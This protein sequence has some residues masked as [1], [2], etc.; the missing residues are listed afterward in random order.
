MFRLQ[1][2]IIGLGVWVIGTLG[3]ISPAAWANP[4]GGTGINPSLS[5]A[6]TTNPEELQNQ[7]NSI[8]QLRD[9]SP[10]NWSYEALRNLVENYGCIQGYPDRTYR[11]DRALTRN[12]FAAGLSAC[13]QQLERRLLEAR[14]LLP[15]TNN[16]VRPLSSTPGDSLNNVFQRAFFNSTGT[17]FDSTSI[18]GQAN[19]IFGWR[20]FPGSFFDNQIT[21]DAQVIGTIYSDAMQ[22]QSA[23]KLV[24]S[25][26][27]TNPFDTSIQQNPDFLRL[28]GTS[29]GSGQASPW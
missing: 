18:S 14:S 20:T 28:E 22:Q 10:Q 13:L 24:R 27:L 11:G 16:A 2:S 6:P 1:G 9:V 17:Y 19:A 23:G 3:V 8:R 21:R 12:E 15:S 25:R 7:I 5:S 29:S 26:D 4:T